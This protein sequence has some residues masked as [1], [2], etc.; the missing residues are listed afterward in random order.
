MPQAC[1]LGNKTKRNNADER[2]ALEDYIKKYPRKRK[3]SGSKVR[4]VSLFSFPESGETWI[5]SAKP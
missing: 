2:W 4:L 1:V 3:T 5:R